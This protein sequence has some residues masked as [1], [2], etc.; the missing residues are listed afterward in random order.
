MNGLK[1]SINRE[2]RGGMLARSS[3]GK[4]KRC[5]EIVYVY[6]GVKKGERGRAAAEESQSVGKRFGNLGLF[7]LVHW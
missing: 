5:R 1:V 6:E 7:L 4:T 2:M 3:L